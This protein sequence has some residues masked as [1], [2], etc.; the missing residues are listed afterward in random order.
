VKPSEAIEANVMHPISSKLTLILG[1]TVMLTAV[2]CGEADITVTDDGAA[3][4]CGAACDD[5]ADLLEALP[6]ETLISELSKNELVAFCERRKA[7][8][9]AFILLQ[10]D[11]ALNCTAQ[12]LD[13]RFEEG[14]DIPACEAE[15]STCIEEANELPA[16]TFELLSCLPY[17]VSSTE[18]AECTLSLDQF[19]ACADALLAQAEALI[20]ALSCSITIEEAARFQARDNTDLPDACDPLAAVCPPLQAE[21]DANAE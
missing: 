20:D 3:D 2:A 11:P 1:T 6:G 16:A 13:L 21:F 9:D 12:G 8:Y 17:Q 18:M 5:D 19:D 10:T 4:A 14:Q 7:F 15:R